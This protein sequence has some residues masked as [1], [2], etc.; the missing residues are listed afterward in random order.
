MEP[1][2]A[3]AKELLERVEV[4]LAMAGTGHQQELTCQEAIPLTIKPSSW[5][6]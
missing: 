1:D 5:Q 3:E 6:S 4:E 2:K